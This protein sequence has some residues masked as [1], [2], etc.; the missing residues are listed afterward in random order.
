MK[1]T[2]HGKVKTYHISDLPKQEQERIMNLVDP[3]R[4]QK[5][6]GFAIAPHLRGGKRR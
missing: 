5:K 6:R 3:Y 2:V 1:K 4:F